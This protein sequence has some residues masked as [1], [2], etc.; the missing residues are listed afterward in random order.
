MVFSQG[1][2]NNSYTCVGIMSGTSLD[3]LDICICEFNVD[4]AGKWNYSI[5]KGETIPYPNDIKTRLVQAPNL[6]GEHLTQF[7]YEYGSW[8]GKTV[9]DFILKSN[10]SPTFVASHG[11]TIFHNPQ[12]G[13]TLQI[14]KGSAISAETSIPCISDFRSSDVCR[15]GQGAPLVP[16]GDKHLFSEF[17]ICLNLGGIANLSYDNNSKL[18]IAFDICPC[19]M[20]L[21]Y[22]AGLLGKEFDPNG[23]IGKK[24]NINSVLLQNLNNIA[25]YKTD[26][27]KS[28]GREWFESQ[29]L[30]MVIEFDCSIEN[31]LR[32]TYEHIAQQITTVTNK[33][34]GNTILITGG[35]AKNDFLIELIRGKSNKKVIIPDE[36]TIDFKEALIFAFLGVLYLENQV[37]ALKTVTGAKKDSICGCLYF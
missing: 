1:S 19:N 33:I 26:S 3:G 30:K 31:K 17:D 25:Y 29:I 22:L 18:R 12:N 13:Y 8:I 27:P 34:S 20:Q 4:I 23:E 5:L 11:H 37:G 16:I 32:T 2:Q 24:G 28:L 9:N 14:G 7:D 35:G 15:G 21:N 6:L 10:E 36:K